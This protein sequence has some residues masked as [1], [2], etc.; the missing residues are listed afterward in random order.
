ME[1]E[2]NREMQ[3][4]G[5]KIVGCQMDRSRHLACHMRTITNNI[6]L[7]TGNLPKEQIL[8]YKINNKGDREEV[9]ML[10]YLTMAITSLCL[11]I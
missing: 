9:C 8:P 7:Y 1:G 5:Y 10:I 6:V 2:K 3:I 4:K 11:C